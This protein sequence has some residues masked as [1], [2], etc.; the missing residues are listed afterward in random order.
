MSCKLSLLL[1][2]CHYLLETNFLAE[3]KNYFKPQSARGMTLLMSNFLISC[4]SVDPSVIVKLCVFFLDILWCFGVIMWLTAVAGRSAVAAVRAVT[5]KDRPG[6]TAEAAVFTMTGRTSKRHK[7]KRISSSEPFHQPFADLSTE[8]HN[9]AKQ[10]TH[11]KN[12]T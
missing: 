5:V 11:L 10:F 1:M 12:N 4:I 7:P 6:L 3:I 8:F 9:G 2:R